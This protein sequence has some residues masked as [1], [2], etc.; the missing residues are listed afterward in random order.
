LGAGEHLTGAFASINPHRT[1]PLLELADGTELFDS[2][3]TSLY[4]DEIFP[5]PN[6]IG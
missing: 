2:N 5:E 6:L 3:S 4:L 1:V